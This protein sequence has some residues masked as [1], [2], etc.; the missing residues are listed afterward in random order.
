MTDI[1]P[2]TPGDDLALIEADMRAA[3]AKH[4]PRMERRLDTLCRIEAMFVLGAL[5]RATLDRFSPAHRERLLA[6]WLDWFGVDEED[7]D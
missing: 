5:L 2:D 7:D 3:V 1:D 4:A 6:G